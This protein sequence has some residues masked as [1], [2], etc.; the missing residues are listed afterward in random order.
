MFR[1]PSSL[2]RAAHG[3]RGQSGLFEVLTQYTRIFKVVTHSQAAAAIRSTFQGGPKS[4]KPMDGRQ[5]P[6]CG[7]NKVD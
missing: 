1:Q 7:E 2:P 5:K 4:Q 3:R 6:F